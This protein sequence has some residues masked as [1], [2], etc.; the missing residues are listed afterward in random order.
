MQRT[1]SSKFWL[2]WQLINDTTDTGKGY[3]VGS[4]CTVCSNPQWKTDSRSLR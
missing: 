2:K 1:A 3:F 4:S